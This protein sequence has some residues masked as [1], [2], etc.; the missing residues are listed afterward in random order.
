MIFLVDKF[1]Y[2]EKILDKCL[3]IIGVLL[4][5]FLG[6]IVGEYIGGMWNLIVKIKKR[7]RLDISE[8][9]KKEIKRDK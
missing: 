3:E 8:I 7:N 6:W 9:L 1:K 2:F 5:G 4:V